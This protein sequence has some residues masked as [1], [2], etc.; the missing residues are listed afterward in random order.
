MR[1]WTI[2]YNT[3][4]TSFGFVYIYVENEYDR[5]MHILADCWRVR[6]AISHTLHRP[7]GLSAH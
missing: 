7:A 6:G 5:S 2:T 3:V 4:H 1:L